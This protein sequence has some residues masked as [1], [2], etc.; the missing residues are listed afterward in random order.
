MPIEIRT[1]VI[2]VVRIYAG[3]G[4]NL[5]G[6]IHSQPRF[7][8]EFVSLVVEQHPTVGLFQFQVAKETDLKETG[9]YV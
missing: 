5:V 7:N 1:H 6:E 3:I 9:I 4:M 8:D 2:Q